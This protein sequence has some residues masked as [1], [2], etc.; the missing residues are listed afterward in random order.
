V[1]CPWGYEGKKEVYCYECHEELLHNPVLLPQDVAAFA[2]LIRRK[3][4]DENTKPESRE[5]IGGRIELLHEVISAGLKTLDQQHEARPILNGA[6]DVADKANGKSCHAIH[7]ALERLPSWRE[8]RQVPFSNGL[9]FFYERGEASPHAPQGRVVRVGN[10]PRSDNSLVRR[11]QQHYSGRKNGSVFRRYVGG[12]LIRALDPDNSCLMPGPGRGHWERH[13]Q[14]TCHLCAAVEQQVSLSLREK[15]TFRCIEIDNRRERNNLEE[16]LIATLSACNE[17]IPS[18]SW[19]GRQACS[20]V[21]RGSGM[22]NCQGVSGEQLSE[23]ELNRLEELVTETA[24]K[25]HL[26]P[27][28]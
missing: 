4:L 26:K 25:W 23:G 9:Y 22:W 21:L 17:C 18:E 12:A 11:L 28:S 3:G 7:A 20:S 1:S 6:N 19:L 13:G 5:K 16:S 10:H 14:D 27:N 24:D 2:D 8:P 15:F